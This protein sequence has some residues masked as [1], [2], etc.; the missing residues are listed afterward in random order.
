MYTGADA[1]DRGL[2]DSLGDLESAAAEARRLAHLPYRARL[3]HVDEPSDFAFSRFDDA[4]SLLGGP[5]GGGVSALLARGPLLWAPLASPRSS[6]LSSPPS[7]HPSDAAGELSSLLFLLSALQ[8][9]P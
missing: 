6:P 1:R 9:S 2:A 5:L 7:S 3:V 8:P 4:L